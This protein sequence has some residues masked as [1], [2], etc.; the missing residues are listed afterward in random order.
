M[1][2]HHLVFGGLS[3]KQTWSNKYH[4]YTYTTNKK[5]E[6]TLVRFSFKT[7]ITFSVVFEIFLLNLWE[8]DDSWGSD[9]FI[10]LIFGKDSSPPEL[11]ATER[12]Q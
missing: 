4:E 1:A 10:P 9:F 2:D 3:K 12:C 5:T 11:E 6:Q 7:Y 8:D